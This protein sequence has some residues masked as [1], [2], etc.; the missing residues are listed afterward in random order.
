MVAADLKKEVLAKE[1]T[2]EDLQ[3]AITDKEQELKKAKELV[4]VWL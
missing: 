2:H 1:K 4:S 3:K